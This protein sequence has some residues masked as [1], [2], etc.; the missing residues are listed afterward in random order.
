ML[1]INNKGMWDRRAYDKKIE[2]YAA[3]HPGRYSISYVN[4]QPPSW[5][6]ILHNAVGL[7]PPLKM[8]GGTNP[9]RKN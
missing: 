2:R 8:P 9:P 6:D 1:R 7:K 3:K 5:D 4:M